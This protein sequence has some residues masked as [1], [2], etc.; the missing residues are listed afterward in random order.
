[1]F[2]KMDLKVHAP[3]RWELWLHLHRFQTVLSL[4]GLLISQIHGS[5]Y[6]GSRWCEKAI[7]RRLTIKSTS[8]RLSAGPGASFAW[9]KAAGGLAAVFSRNPPGRNASSI[10]YFEYAKPSAYWESKAY[11]VLFSKIKRF[12]GHSRRSVSVGR[13]CL[14]EETHVYNDFWF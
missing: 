12:N 4:P 6:Q 3:E 1:M 10:L 14:R 5:T 8:S 7:S 11:D 2:T 9:A 13:L